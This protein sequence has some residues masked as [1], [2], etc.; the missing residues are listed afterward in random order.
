MYPLPE[1]IANCM[2]WKDVLIKTKPKQNRVAVGAWDVACLKST[3]LAH[4]R[5]DVIESSAPDNWPIFFKYEE[6]L[7]WNEALEDGDDIYGK[8]L[9]HR[10]MC[11]FISSVFNTTHSSL[12][13]P[14]YSL[15]SQPMKVLALLFAVCKPWKLFWFEIKINLPR[16]NQ[17]LFSVLN[18]F[19]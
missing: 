1:M 9:L 11:S 10:F 15:C 13:L 6:V 7:P 14:G 5:L 8:N 3:C 18:S 2:E 16:N 17:L 19:F 4:M 12:R